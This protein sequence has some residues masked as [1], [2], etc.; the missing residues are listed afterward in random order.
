MSILYH[1][2]SEKSID[3]SAKDHKNFLCRTQNFKEYSQT[4]LQKEGECGI[5]IMLRAFSETG[6]MMTFRGQPI[7]GDIRHSEGGRSLFVCPNREGIAPLK[8]QKK[9]DP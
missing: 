1:K 7:R 4:Y 5:I 9:S 2:N 3:K 6:W 8:K